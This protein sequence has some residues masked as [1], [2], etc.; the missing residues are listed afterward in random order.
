MTPTSLEYN[1]IAGDCITSSCAFSNDLEKYP[2]Q[3]QYADNPDQ[4]K[5]IYFFDKD[6][7]TIGRIG[8]ESTRYYLDG[9]GDNGWFSYTG[10]RVVNSYLNTWTL[11]K[12]ST[13]ITLKQNETVLLETTFADNNCADKYGGEVVSAVSFQYFATADTKGTWREEPKGAVYTHLHPLI[14]ITWFHI[15]STESNESH[16]LMSHTH[17]IIC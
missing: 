10:T 5:V 4:Y 16:K 17:T 1:S 14:R 3:I 12:T 9:C 13:T 7:S 2:V 15:A 6:G 11:S 8:W